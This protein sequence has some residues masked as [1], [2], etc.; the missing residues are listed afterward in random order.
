MVKS[1]FAAVAG[2][3]AHQS[4]LDVIGNNIAN[5]N[6]YG[7]KGS[8]VIFK[9]VYY[10]TT[11]AASGSGEI[12]GGGN[13]SQ[14]GYGSR[15]GSI[16]VMHSAAN[17]A[18]T[19]NNMD[20]MVQGD[21]YFLV[22]TKNIGDLTM[23][24]GQDNSEELSKLNL[25]RVGNFNFDNEGYLVDGNKNL[26][27]GYEFD[28]DGNPI[29]G[30]LKPIRRPVDG[31]TPPAVIELENIQVAQDGTITAKRSSDG[32]MINIGQIAVCK[33]ANPNGLEASQGGYWNLSGNTGRAEAHTAGEGGTGSLLTSYLEMPNVDLAREFTDMITTQRGFQAN[34]RIITVTDEMLQEL[35][36]LKR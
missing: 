27:Y 17:G 29:P 32:T 16:D 2:L 13:P 3:R 6:T 12:Y 35:V 33:V 31:N 8:R 30:T 10:Q 28:T 34:S 26:V 5:V 4:K 7:F 23:T 18:P 24:P 14:V 36:N 21:G 9:D 19:D 22:G 15:V 1:M 25:T 11:A 20:M